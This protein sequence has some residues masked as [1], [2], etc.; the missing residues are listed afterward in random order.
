MTTNILFTCV[1]RRNYLINYFKEALN[2]CGKIFASDVDIYAPAMIDADVALVVPNV[3]DINYIPTIT[4][5]IKAY[6]INFSY[7]LCQRCTKK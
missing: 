1:G 6:N 7:K 3:H 2:G 5:L 4:E